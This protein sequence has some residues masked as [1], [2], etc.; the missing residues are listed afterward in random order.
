M[1]DLSSLRERVRDHG[2]AV[3]ELA[4]ETMV[5]DLRAGAPGSLGDTVEVDTVESSTGFSTTVR[6][7]PA[8]ARSQ[9]EGTGIYGPAGARIVATGGKPMVFEIDG[10]TVFAMST[11]GVPATRW[12]SNVMIAE[13]WSA[14]LADALG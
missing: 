10:V 14:A 9:D 6:S 8:H 3:H 4:V 13:R 7:A 5:A 1:A 2:R 11:T 12:W